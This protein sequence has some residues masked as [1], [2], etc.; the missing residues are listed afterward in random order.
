MLF[1]M[2]CNA[3]PAVSAPAKPAPAKA[4]PAKSAPAEATPLKCDEETEYR[5]WVVIDGRPSFCNDA[6]YVSCDLT[7][8]NVEEEG[9]SKEGRPY[10]IMDA[11][12]KRENDYSSTEFEK[13]LQCMKRGCKKYTDIPKEAREMIRK[14]QEESDNKKKDTGK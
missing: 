12:L 3:A 13:C 14:M 4:A 7:N 9:K 10:Q 8:I 5:H 1:A 2:Q 11:K 6:N